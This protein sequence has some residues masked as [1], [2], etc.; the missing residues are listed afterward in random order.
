MSIFG[1]RGEKYLTDHYFILARSPHSGTVR[2][3]TRAFLKVEKQEFHFLRVFEVKSDMDFV[4]KPDTDSNCQ[5][6]K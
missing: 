3:S 1:S 6:I 2:S 4:K 5:V